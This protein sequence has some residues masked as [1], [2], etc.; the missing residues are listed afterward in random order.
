M[1]LT[2]SNPTLAVIKPV[3]NPPR[4]RVL[5]DDELRRLWRACRDDDHGRI[6][7]LLILTACRRAEIGDM[8]WDELD[9]ER[10]TFTI[11]AARSKN[12]KLHTLPLPAAAVDI[13][14]AVPRMV[15]R[16]QLFGQRS[17]GFTRW[18][19]GKLEL[20]QR[21]GVSDWTYHDLRRTAATRL[22]DLGTQ[23]HVIECILN[24]SSGFRAGVAATYNR[25]P[26][27]REMT[28]A[29]AL[30]ADH[31]RTLVEGGERKIVAF[32]AAN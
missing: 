14:K 10:G 21:T 18:H 11:A 26:Y 28:A 32:G 27:L 25:S 15:S 20:D 6:I 19:K 2:E 29:L 3:L 13:I 1:G 12:G 4:E 24:H 9:P 30:W 7:R 23:P 22:G 8:T 5:S 16:E 31:I 17:H